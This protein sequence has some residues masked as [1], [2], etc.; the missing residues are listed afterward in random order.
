LLGAAISLAV[1]RDA[2]LRTLAMSV[3]IV[4]FAWPSFAGALGVARV[5]ATAP[6]T[7]DVLLRSRFTVC[8]V[9]ALHLAPIA[10]A[11]ALRGVG[12]IAPSWTY[13]AALHGVAAPRYLRLVLWPALRPSLS[14]SFALVALLASAD[15]G[16]VLLLH[17]PGEASF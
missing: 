7:L 16:T 12:A 13:A 1:G 5:A 14:M 4:L 3:C 17:P 10:I 6:A 11:L 9:L 8:S 15:A 2:S